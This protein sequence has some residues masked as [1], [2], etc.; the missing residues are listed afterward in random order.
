MGETVADREEQSP[1]C[2]LGDV[3]DSPGFGASTMARSGRVSH[4]AIVT[5]GETGLFAYLSRRFAGDRRTIV[6]FDRRRHDRQRVGADEPRWRGVERRRPRDYWHDITFHWVIVTRAREEYAAPPSAFPRG[7]ARMN[8]VE[9][10]VADDR[11]R[12]DR[13]IE[14]SQYVIGRLIPGLLDDRD[15]WRAKAQ[16][17]EEETERLRQELGDARRGI[18]QLETE[19]REW[20]GEHAAIAEAFNRAMEHLTHLRE[21]LGELAKRLEPTQA[22][23]VDTAAA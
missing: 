10:G 3:G 1:C 12:V 13:W 7:E 6:L 16:A 8:H 19:K 11:P 18:A 5:R 17:A 9:M 2:A 21:P 20:Y 22:P 15:R 4:L 23:T 14:D